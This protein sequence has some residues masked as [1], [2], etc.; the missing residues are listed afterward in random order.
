MGQR[1]LI[2][3]FIVLYCFLYF[4]L[5]SSFYFLSLSQGYEGLG[6]P[7]FGGGDDGVFYAEQAKNIANGLPAILT[8][9]HALIYGYIFKL[10]NT[11]SIFILRLFNYIGNVFLAIV[12][13]LM[14]RKTVSYKMN[15]STPGIVLVVLL[16]YYPSLLLN[17]NLSIYRDVW[18]CFY[19]L[20]SI[21][22]FANL[23]I[24]KSRWPLLINFILLMV[25]VSLLGGYRKYA[26][27]SFL[28]GSVF[29]FIF[30]DISIIFFCF[31]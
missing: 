28:T 21:M 31:F 17:T 10:F 15:F 5:T 26:L 29:Y 9:V 25:S 23:F 27:M 3:F 30:I 12:S 4:L 14:L 20:W 7:L 1:F 8:S 11:E 6:L 18:I 22:L 13:L 16:L 24:V 2:P 19:Y